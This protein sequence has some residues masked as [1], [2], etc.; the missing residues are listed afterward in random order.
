MIEGIVL[1]R[2]LKDHVA[3]DI[4]IE[5]SNKTYHCHKIIL[6]SKSDKLDELCHTVESSNS[7]RLD[8]PSD[9]VDC[10]F[11]YVYSGIVDVPDSFYMILELISLAKEW[12]LN[13]LHSILQKKYEKQTNQFTYN[14]VTTTSRNDIWSFIQLHQDANY[15]D[16]KIKDCSTGKIYNLHKA[17]LA[18]QS[19]YF[20]SMF[21]GCWKEKEEKDSILLQFSDLLYQ[22]FYQGKIEWE[23]VSFDEL[24]DLCSIA[25]YYIIEDLVNLCEIEFCRFLSLRNINTLFPLSNSLCLEDLK[26]SIIHYIAKH[27]KDFTEQDDFIHTDKALLKM[28]LSTGCIELDFNTIYQSILK[29]GESQTN[30]SEKK[31]D[32]IIQDL[33]PPHVLFNSTNKNFLVGNPNPLFP[34]KRGQH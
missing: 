27:F 28:V 13:S 18:C 26:S 30:D 16:F 7:I 20:Y 12:E 21:T 6:A 22:Y 14:E 24:L 2:L 29:W 25:R 11:K 32:I 33:L 3:S 15:S 19:E 23:N 10:A 31:I 9:V 34:F 8:Y 5:T 1:K 4:V 17:I